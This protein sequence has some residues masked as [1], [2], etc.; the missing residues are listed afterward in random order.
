MKKNYVAPNVEWLVVSVENG[1]AVSPTTEQLD[2][3][4]VEW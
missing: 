4:N 1:V 3:E 2:K